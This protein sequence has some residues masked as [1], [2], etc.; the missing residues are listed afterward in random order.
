MR[1]DWGSP[2]RE[3]VWTVRDRTRVLQGRQEVDLV[4]VC[5]YD[6]IAR[7]DIAAVAQPLARGGLRAYSAGRSLNDA[8][9]LLAGLNDFATLKADF[10]RIHEPGAPPVVRLRDH[11]A[12]AF[13]LADPV[14]LSR[15]LSA[16]RYVMSND[17]AI[18]LL[19]LNERRRVGASVIL[20]VAPASAAS[21]CLC[22]NAPR[23]VPPFAQ[24]W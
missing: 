7:S 19:I 24:M 2:L 21:K 20:C 3:V 16:A 11:L 6:G 12:P 9:A 8:R 18:K 5:P 14:R 10:D 4:V 15:I 17:F 1:R 22:T 23:P 13:G